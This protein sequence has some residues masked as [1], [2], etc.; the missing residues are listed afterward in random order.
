MRQYTDQFRPALRGAAKVTAVFG[1]AVLQRLDTIAEGVTVR[2]RTRRYVEPMVF[3]APGTKNLEVP[4]GER[5]NLA[6]IAVDTAASLITIRSGGSLRYVRLF[7]APDTS[8]PDVT[9]SAGPGAPIDISCDKAAQ[10]TLHIDIVESAD[11]QNTPGAGDRLPRGLPSNAV[12]TEIERHFPGV[13]HE[14]E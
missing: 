10:V 3:T 4:A 14:T 12:G 11:P 2:T 5:W 6:L 8:G 13:L 7:S 1:A 9:L